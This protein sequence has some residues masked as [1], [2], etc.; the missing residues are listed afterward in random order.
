MSI[1]E[2]WQKICKLLGIPGGLVCRIM[3]PDRRLWT[4]CENLRNVG[5]SS[6][7][8]FC[9]KYGA[10]V[11]FKN[12]NEITYGSYFGP[13]KCDACIRSIFERLD[14]GELK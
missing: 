5:N 13:G 9:T 10:K 14:G 6:T 2:K 3:P 1:L 11:Y 12:I 8:M 4:L 7:H